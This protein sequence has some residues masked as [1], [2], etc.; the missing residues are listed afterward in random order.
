MLNMT[1]GHSNW[2]L[3][4]V[5]FP[6]K[7]KILA[8]GSQD[9]S[10]CVLNVSTGGLKFKMMGHTFWVIT[11]TS[12]DEHLLASRSFSE[13]FF[14]NVTDGTQ[15]FT[16]TAFLAIFKRHLHLEKIPTQDLH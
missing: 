16:L 11:M 15:N 1:D 13:L 6:N 14:W 10:I 8:S 7:A 9:M 4:M 5:A 12:L 3:N 2:I